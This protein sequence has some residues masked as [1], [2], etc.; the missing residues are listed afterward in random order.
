MT[1]E[2]AAEQQHVVRTE[3]PKKLYVRPDNLLWHVVAP[4]LR[5][6]KAEI[7]DAIGE[8]VAGLYDGTG[9]DVTP[10]IA[11][12]LDEL[13]GNAPGLWIELQRAKDFRQGVTF[14]GDLIQVEDGRQFSFTQSRPP[15][16]IS[17]RE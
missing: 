8:D 4:V 2:Q 5:R 7:D 11:A 3:P 6:T 17:R 16:K 13:C 14:A 1:E 9:M 12:R 15:V 10:T